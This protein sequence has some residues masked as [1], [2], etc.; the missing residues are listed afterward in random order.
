M[1]LCRATTRRSFQLIG[2]QQVTRA[3]ND[4][5]Q[6]APLLEKI[7]EQSGQKPPEVIADSGYCSEENLKC[8][9]YRKISGFGTTGKQK[10]NPR[11]KP[12]KPWP[13]PKG[14]SRVEQM[15]R[16]LRT[17]VGRRCMRHENSSWNRYSGKS[18]RRADSD[19]FSYADWRKYEGSGH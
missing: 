9:K 11:R 3:A 13:L 7:K 8:L 2:G 18:N 6:L 5:Q 19:S 14:A 12:Y 17:Q 10:H 4:K 15:E 1:D 16:K